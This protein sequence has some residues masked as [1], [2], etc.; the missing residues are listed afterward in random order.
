MAERTSSE[1]VRDLFFRMGAIEPTPVTTI[2]S[3]II[4]VINYKNLNTA[5]SGME[6]ARLRDFH[7]AVARFGRTD[8]GVTGGDASLRQLTLPAVQQ[9]CRLK[10]DPRAAPGATLDA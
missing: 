6:F 4:R 5:L 8:D 1:S 10:S 2:I 7:S 9:F 3:H